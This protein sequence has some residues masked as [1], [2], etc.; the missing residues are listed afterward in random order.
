MQSKTNK[1]PPHR[2]DVGRGHG[3]TNNINTYLVLASY[4]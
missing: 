3:S 2:F 4:E 1:I